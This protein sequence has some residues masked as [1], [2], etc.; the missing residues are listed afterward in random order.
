MAYSNMLPPGLEQTIADPLQSVTV[1]PADVVVVPCD[2]LVFSLSNDADKSSGKAKAHLSIHNPTDQAIIFKFKTNAGKANVGVKPCTGR[3]LPGDQVYVD[4]S[5]DYGAKQDVEDLKVL[6]V[7]APAPPYDCDLKT[8]WKHLP[9]ESFQTNELQCV[10]NMPQAQTSSM[11]PGQFQQPQY[12][13]PQ[14]Q[15]A[16]YQEQA[17][18][19]TLPSVNQGTM[20][21]SIPAGARHFVDTNNKTVP[22]M[23]CRQNVGQPYPYQYQPQFAAQNMARE[24]SKIVQTG[25]AQCLPKMQVPIDAGSQVNQS[26]QQGFPNFRQCLTGASHDLGRVSYPESSGPTSYFVDVSTV[27]NRANKRVPEQGRSTI[28]GVDKHTVLQTCL[29][30]IAAIAATKLFSD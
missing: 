21:G 19:H 16:R 25:A 22:E 13:T 10:V 23:Q 4:V 12:Q 28:F 30:G 5:L 20:Q 9:Q 3:I 8:V 26:L 6:V 17:K 11:F 7:T 18:M 14:A 29:L 24:P 15:A 2:K 27:A 1:K